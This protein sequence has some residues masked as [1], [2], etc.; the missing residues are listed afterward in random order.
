ARRRAAAA[1]A[2]AEAR[3]EPAPVLPLN[4]RAAQSAEYSRI[5]FDW[6]RPVEHELAQE[7]G[8]VEVRFSRDALVDLRSLKVS[9]VRGMAGVSD[10]HQDD[11]LS[12]RLA[13]EE[14]YSARSWND[15]P[16]VVV[17]LAPSELM[18]AR[19]EESEALLAGLESAAAAPGGD[20]HD[21]SAAG[22]HGEAGDH[23]A[24]QADLAHAA[25]GGASAPAATRSPVGGVVKAEVTRTGGSLHAA[26]RWDAP[27]GAAAFRRGEAIWI[28][29]DAP[30]DLD[31]D[32]LRRAG[33][34]QIADARAYRGADY[35]AVRAIAPRATQISA[36]ADGARWIFVFSEAI[37][38]SPK[39]IDL[40]GE[41]DGAQDA[42]LVAGLEGATAVLQVHDPEVGDELIVATAGA[43]VQGLLSKRI[44][45][46]AAALPSA[47]GLGFEQRVDD[48]VATLEH[49]RVSLA[50]EGG[51]RLTP[52]R[53]ALRAGLATATPG[54]IDF[55]GWS[56]PPITFVD[57]HDALARRAAA[58]EEAEDRMALARFLVAHEMGAEALGV[59]STLLDEEPHYGG[60]ARFLALRGAANVLAGRLDEAR[61]D[62]GAPALTRDPAAALWRGWLAA[63]DHDWREARRQFEAGAET[64]YLFRPDWRGRFRTAEARAAL[65]LNDLGAAKTAVAQALAEDPPLDVALEA[66]LVEAAYFEAAGELERAIEIA[67]DVETGGYEPLEARAS[68]ELT[69][70]E[71]TLGHITNEEAFDRL[72]TLRFRW[73]GD[74]AEFGIVAELGRFYV[75]Q[76]DVRRGLN[77]MRAAVKR[78]PN[79]P[80][81]RQMSIQMSD[82]FRRLYIEGEADR[83]DPVRA[84]GL[85]YEFSDLTPIG[86]DGDYMIRRLADRLVDFDL[87]QQAAELLQHQVDNRLRGAAKAQV[88]TDLAA[89]Y[90][91]DRRPEDALAAI[92]RSRIARL[93]DA[94]NRERRLMEARALSELGRKDHAL[95]LLARDP[96]PEARRL[97]ADIAWEARDWEQAGPLL[98]TAAGEA[99]RGQGLLSPAEESAV[100]RAA[101]AFS[102]AGERD[103]LARLKERFDNAMSRS[104]EASSWR[105]VTEDATTD[106]VRL[107]DLARRMAATESLESFLDDFRARRLEAARAAGEAV[108]AGG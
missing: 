61:V 82:L 108:A 7:D 98:E 15:G 6:T 107:K 72:E 77:L 89:V 9:P 83:M 33:D 17:D 36:T 22:D 23:G 78:F 74:D 76:G 91:M 37:A 63:R 81:A 56:G 28:V 62:F 25:A 92:S 59:L 60:D 48:L 97:R 18:T 16:K 49:G 106:G 12:V 88:A 94:L 96:T 85:W 41:A 3:S 84:L 101:I 1:A 34:R 73:R 40:V 66:R 75:E 99:W 20:P 64:L 65:E 10:S 95:E 55:V 100:L 35:S 103:R 87:L 26:F 53:T 50:R 32:E 68:H 52:R 51:L 70:L 43:P 46:E 44:F 4:V 58:T 11:R 86:A 105:L 90:L 54:L 5:V 19:A 13:L 29:F 42:R 27:V 38:M 69:R 80:A 71:R 47:H 14:G 104:V 21:P 57:S 79:A 31:L 45:V 93:P 39:P 102:L 30:V 2:L 24:G 8:A 67:R